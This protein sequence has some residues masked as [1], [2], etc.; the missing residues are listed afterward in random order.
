M[1]KKIDELPPD[2]FVGEAAIV[3]LTNKSS[4]DRTITRNDLARAGSHIKAGDIVLLKTGYDDGFPTEE[5][6]SEEYM[7]RSPYLT[8]DAVE[9]LIQKRIKLLGIDFWSIEAFSIN[10]R[11]G[12]PRHIMLFNHE[13]PLI[14]SLVNLTKLEANRALFV[15][16]PLPISGLDSSPVRAVAIEV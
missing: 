15:A 12:E 9:W 5:M 4:E 16:L 13:I 2:K 11:V 14:H 10:P 7:S 6:Q 1:G 3:D 8:Y